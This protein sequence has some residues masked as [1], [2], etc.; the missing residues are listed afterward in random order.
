MYGTT[1]GEIKFHFHT[2]ITTTITVTAMKRRKAAEKHDLLNFKYIG[3]KISELKSV[4]LTR[5]RSD[6]F[7]FFLLSLLLIQKNVKFY[8]LNLHFRKW[9]RI[10]LLKFGV[11]K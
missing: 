4:D 5:N 3:I 11:L 7:L 1:R 2:T 6:A 9:P 10:K 8:K